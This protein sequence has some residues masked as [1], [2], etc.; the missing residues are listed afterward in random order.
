[1]SDSVAFR[2]IEKLDIFG[3]Q[4]PSFSLGGRT[5]V[6]SKPGAVLT[7]IILSL[8]LVFGLVK[9]QHLFEKKNAQINTNL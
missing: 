4:L 5:E 7:I 9:L 3:M 8:T 2:F 1:M 6:R